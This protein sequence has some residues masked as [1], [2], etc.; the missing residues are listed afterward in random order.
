LRHGLDDDHGQ[1]RR[2]L[3]ESSS[4]RDVSDGSSV[5]SVSS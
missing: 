3:D 4:A 1:S 5:V 2:V